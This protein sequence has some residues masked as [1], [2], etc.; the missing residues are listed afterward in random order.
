MVKSD[1][2]Y[3]SDF[4]KLFDSQD[5]TILDYA[6]KARYYNKLYYS[7]QIDESEY[8]ELLYNLTRIENIND[9]KDDSERYNAVLH[10]LALISGLNN[11]ITPL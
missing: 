5:S 7:S 9:I 4:Q 1:E 11:L 8:R 10:A 6:N 3:K 2:E